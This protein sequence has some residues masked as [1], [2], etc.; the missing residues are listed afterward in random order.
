MKFKVNSES[1]LHLINKSEVVEVIKKDR[2]GYWLRESSND[3][4]GDFFSYISDVKISDI[5]QK[6]SMTDFVHLPACSDLGV[7]G[8]SIDNTSG[9]V[10]CSIYLAYELKYWDK[11]FSAD[12]FFK[13]FIS[14]IESGG[15]MVALYDEQDTEIEL[16]IYDIKPDLQPNMTVK[17]LFTSIVAPIL[18]QERN[19]CIKLLEESSSTVFRKIFNFPDKYSAV[20]T[21]YI[22]WFGELLKRLGMQASLSTHSNEFGLLLSIEHNGNMELTEKIEQL[23]YGYLSLPYS[24]YIPRELPTD[25]N[26][27]MD[28]LLLKNQVDQ[29]KF[30]LLQTKNALEIASLKNDT[31]ALELRQKEDELVL[32]RAAKESR[33][34]ILG[35]ALSLE[36]FKVCGVTV[37]PKKAYDLLKSEGARDT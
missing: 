24:E 7:H 15:N 18:D 4:I 26:E 10:V 30:N 33:L 1:E 25:T 36:E 28:L 20:C 16:H 9:E 12:T 19:I 35:G 32:L 21:Q 5:P 17:E 8:A 3:T 14:K 22:M 23:F 2:Q 34:E 6:Y 37:N 31:L 27:K 11:P 29:F 13:E